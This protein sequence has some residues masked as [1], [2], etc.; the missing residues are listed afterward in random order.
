MRCI[1]LL[2]VVGSHISTSKVTNEAKVECTS[3]E[4]LFQGTAWRSCLFA[5]VSVYLRVAVNYVRV[6]GIART[7]ISMTVTTINILKYIIVI[8]III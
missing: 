3:A 2:L 5:L 7:F 1:K 4:W 6:L 8:I